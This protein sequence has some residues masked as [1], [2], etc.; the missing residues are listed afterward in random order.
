MPD[1]ARLHSIPSPVSGAEN[2]QSWTLLTDLCGTETE[3]LSRLSRSTRTQVRRAER[4]GVTVE[5]LNCNCPETLDGFERFFNRFANTKTGFRDVLNVSVQLHM[6][7]RYATA[8]MLEISRAI[9]L[10]GKPVVYHV[11]IV[12]GGRARVHHSASLFRESDN[13]AQRHF[14]GWANRFLHW[15]DMLYYLQNGYSLY[16]MGGWYA[17]RNDESLL[18]VNKFKEEFG[19]KVVCEYDAMVGCS[20]AGKMALIAR[21]LILGLPYAIRKSLH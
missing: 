1:I 16:D 8:S 12:A 18:R 21:D 14:M 5:R 6:L 10:D 2:T 19:G 9:G 20:L 17:G 4:E 11:F 15:C 13:S 3:L 7:K